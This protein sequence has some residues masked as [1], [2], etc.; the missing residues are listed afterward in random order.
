MQ[1][2]RVMK[3]VHTALSKKPATLFKKRQRPRRAAAVKAMTKIQLL[4][5]IEQVERTSRKRKRKQPESSG[6]PVEVKY[7]GSVYHL[8][9][10]NS[11]EETMETKEFAEDTTNF[12][13]SYQPSLQTAVKRQKAGFGGWT[14]MG[15]AIQE[16]SKGWVL[17]MHRAG[18]CSHVTDKFTSKVL[19]K[20]PRNEKCVPYCYNALTNRHRKKGNRLL[21]LLGCQASVM[22]L[23]RLSEFAELRTIGH[24]CLSRLQRTWTTG[25]R[26]MMILNGHCYGFYVH[27]VS[28]VLVYDPTMRS[29]VLFDK[30]TKL[31]AEGPIYQIGKKMKIKF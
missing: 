1:N 12:P 26:F 13:Q 3:A 18:F 17:N 30:F 14:Q 5:Q 16:A 25:D 27:N 7:D 23:R 20:C 19:W 28:T 4:K 10:L 15:G 8:K 2:S 24:N 6:V 21:E 29:P 9:W 22:D 11:D 31:H